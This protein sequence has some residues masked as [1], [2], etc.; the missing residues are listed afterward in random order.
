[1]AVYGQEVRVRTSQ[2]ARQHL[3][4]KG[5]LPQ[6]A[7]DDTPLQHIAINFLLDNPNVS[8]ALLGITREE[9]LEDAFKLLDDRSK[10]I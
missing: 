8:V 1:L 2:I 10:D 5:L 6:N 4:E 9:Y 3:K 7:S